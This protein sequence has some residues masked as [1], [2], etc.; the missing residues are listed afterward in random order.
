MKSDIDKYKINF[1]GFV[2]AVIVVALALFFLSSCYTTNIRLQKQ[3]ISQNSEQNEKKVPEQS[4]NFI[5]LGFGIYAKTAPVRPVCNQ[6][7]VLD[8]ATFEMTVLDSI[9]HF[10]VGGIYS[11]RH[12][13]VY[14]K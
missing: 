9:I 3:P 12:V 2:P 7:Q 14:C 1:N 5:S 10:T 4:V 11:T 8:H 6:G 13:R